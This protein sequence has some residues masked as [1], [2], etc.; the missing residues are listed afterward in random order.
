M[1]DYA[2]D[3]FWI[4]SYTSTRKIFFSFLSFWIAWRC[5]VCA[6]KEQGRVAITEPLSVPYSYEI[7]REII[8][9]YYFSILP[10]TLHPSLF[11]KSHLSAGVLKISALVK[12]AFGFV[13]CRTMFSVIQL[14][15]LKRWSLRMK[16][17]ENKYWKGSGYKY[18][19]DC[20]R[21]Q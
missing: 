19:P 12:P 5:G 15:S 2:P 16:T 20:K 18:W 8:T 3:P 21:I 1:H 13:F 10:I 6:S 14:D 9:P 11:W 7:T 17:S 4:S